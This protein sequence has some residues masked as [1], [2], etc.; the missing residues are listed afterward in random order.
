MPHEE[1]WATEKSS[2][3]RKRNPSI[4]MD[5]HLLAGGF[6]LSALKSSM[7]LPRQICQNWD[8]SG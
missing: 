6:L 4:R 1:F 5:L 2:P 7:V 8:A 3:D